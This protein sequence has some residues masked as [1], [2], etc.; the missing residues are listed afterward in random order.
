M[1]DVGTY[2]E[3]IDA[4][5]DAN[6]NYPDEY[7]I[8]LTDDIELDD[9]QDDLFG[10]VGLPV[11]IAKLT[12]EGNG[13]TI[14]RSE[15]VSTPEF[16]LF[17]INAKTSGNEEATLTL[18]NLVAR[19]GL[20]TNYGAAFMVNDADV[21]LDNCQILSNQGQGTGGIYNGDNYTLSV[22]NCFFAD[23]VGTGENARGGAIYNS[24]G[25]SLYIENTLFINNQ[26]ADTG[27]LGGAIYRHS[28][29]GVTLRAK[30]YQEFS[31]KVGQRFS[32]K[33]Y[34]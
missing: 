30:M 17:A 18:K 32:P 31:P 13:H 16:R 24:S 21:E 22:K 2:Q 27:S 4:I 12:I 7:T 14:F 33:L 20:L 10:P 23:N 1:T 5:T 6:D 29:G 8:N 15:A 28:G 9:V 3:L 19:G 26:A 34:Q 25:S 11:I